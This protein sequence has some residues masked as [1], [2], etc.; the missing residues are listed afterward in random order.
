MTDR[1]IFFGTADFS[2]PALQALIDAEFNVVAVVTKADR[3]AGRG[4]K[5]TSP[6][7]K[8]VADLH[9]IPVLQP[10]KLKDAF[11]ELQSLE[12]TAGVVVAYGKIIPQS[13]ID[14]FPKGIINVH[15]SVL[16][17][18]RGPSPIEAAILA[19]DG[20]TGISLMQIVLAMDAG[21]V[22]SQ[23]KIKLT[24]KETKPELYKQLSKLGSELLVKDLGDI[25]AGRLKPTDQDDSKATIC[26]MIKK[27]DGIIDWSKPAM[28]LD[29]QIRAYLGWPGSRTTLADTEVIITAAHVGDPQPGELSKNGL[30]ID[31]LKPVGKNEMT[32]TQFL[33]G[34][35][36]T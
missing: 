25:L 21:P 11:E 13:V 31:K 30:I 27:E 8:L 33:A 24:G 15:G 22:Y 12:P 26:S 2:A 20:E 35:K 32:G 14:L 3:P 16:P 10:E 4:Q 36:Y 18:Y 17:K 28:E 34:H 6:K 19:G 23:A 7:V 9:K 1:L 29:R 5:T